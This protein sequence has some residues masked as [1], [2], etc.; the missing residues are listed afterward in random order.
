MLDKQELRGWMDG[1][2]SKWMDV[3]VACGWMDG[4]SDGLN[5]VE[6]FVNRQKWH[7]RHR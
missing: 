2:L 5:E 4:C 6:L 7:K 3:R 1:W